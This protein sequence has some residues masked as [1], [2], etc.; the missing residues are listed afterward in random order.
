MELRHLETF[1][2]ITELKSFSKAAEELYCTQPTVSKQIIDLENYFKIKLLDRT[3][4]SVALTRAGELLL[5]YA[6]DFISLKKEMIEAIDAFKGLKTGSILVGASSIPGIYIIPQALNIFK[7]KY[8]GIKVKLIISDSKEII[9][10]MEHGEID[11]GFVGAKDVS[12]NLNYK[13]LFDDTIVIAA[14]KSFPDSINIKDLRDYPI[15]I[16]ET[17][18]GTR[19][20]F[21]SALRRLHIDI[22]DNLKVVAEL[23]DTEAIKETVKHGLG[24]TYISKMAIESEVKKGAVKILRIDGLK[25]LRRSFFIITKKGK[26]ILPHVRALMDTMDTWRRNEKN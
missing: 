12:K 10:K 1:V 17:G 14:P 13:R 15:I 3:K 9:G 20:C 7:Q 4:R 18:S 23:T 16:R 2:K 24:M 19:D 8:D 26:T 6:K 21:D 5:R 22:T 11:I 25:E